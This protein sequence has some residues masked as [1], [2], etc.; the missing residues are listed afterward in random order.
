M[1]KLLTILF[2]ALVLTASLSAAT[3]YTVT[4]NIS[5]YEL[6]YLQTNNFLLYGFK[7]VNSSGTEGQPLTWIVTDNYAEATTITWYEQYGAYD[8]FVDIQNGTNIT[9]ANQVPMDLR[10]LGTILPKT[11]I[12]KVTNDGTEG[13]ITLHDTYA[14]RNQI[15]AGITQ[16]V[17]G[18]MQQLCAFPITNQEVMTFEPVEYV[19]F[20]FATKPYDTGTVI[21]KALNPAIQIDLTGVTSRSVVYNKNDWLDN[22]ES[23]VAQIPALDVL[24]KYLINPDQQKKKRARR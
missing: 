17:N 19:V 13:E 8:S 5:N 14:K 7:G 11:A 21:M 2:C 9:A 24:A 10:Q 1:K 6:N 3:K 16:M 23:W 15:T 18:Q 22:K 20:F 12:I 4:I